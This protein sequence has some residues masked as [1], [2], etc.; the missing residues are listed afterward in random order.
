MLPLA[1]LRRAVKKALSF[2][3]AQADVAEVEVFASAGAN[4][5]VR[6]NHASSCSGCLNGRLVNVGWY[7]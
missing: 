1:D 3:S 6:L 4:L 5:T 2:A 7:N